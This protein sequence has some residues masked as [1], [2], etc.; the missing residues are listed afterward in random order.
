MKHAKDLGPLDRH[1][2]RSPR[3]GMS[4]ENTSTESLWPIA[5]VVGLM[6]LVLFVLEYSGL[7][8]L[9]DGVVLGR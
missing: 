5:F 2:T 6:F 3:P 4:S 1:Q 8:N 7:L 9:V